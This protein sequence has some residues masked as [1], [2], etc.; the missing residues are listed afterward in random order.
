MRRIGRMM[1]RTHRISYRASPHAT[2]PYGQECSDSFR[3]VGGGGTGRT[4]WSKHHPNHILPA[5]SH[6]FE[7]NY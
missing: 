2:N 4:G 6:H 5:A 1:A 3:F 7:I